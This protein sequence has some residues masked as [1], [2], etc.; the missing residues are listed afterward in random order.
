MSHKQSLNWPSMT[1]AYCMPQ[2]KTLKLDGN[3]NHS[4]RTRSSLA[5]SGPL[6]TIHQRQVKLYPQNL[7]MMLRRR[8]LMLVQVLYTPSQVIW[9]VNSR[10]THKVNLTLQWSIR[11]LIMLLQ[12]SPVDLMLSIWLIQRHQSF[13]LVFNSILNSEQCTANEWK[14]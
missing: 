8:L 3:M 5:N 2:Q 1:L 10:L 14:N 7:V 9:L 12:H 11:F 13:L 4:I 6:T